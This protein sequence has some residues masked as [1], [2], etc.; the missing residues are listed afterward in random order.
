MH[1]HYLQHVPFEGL[2][3]IEPWL[4]AAG[5]EITNTRLFE[6]A[7]FPDLKKI[8]LLVIMGGPMSVNDENT[9]PWLVSEKQFICKAINSGNPVLGICLGAQLIASA[10][11]ARVYRNSEKEIGWFPI[12]GVASTDRSIFNFPPSMKVFHWHGETFDLPSGA[13]HLAKSDGC[14]NQAFQIGKSVIGLQFH[15]ETTPKAAWEIVSHCRKELVP[16]K[17]IQT[18]EEILS[19]TP[20]RYKSINQLMGS[21]LSFLLRKDG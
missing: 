1:A 19:A 14:E 10:M 15:L 17:Y 16:S 3:S 4:K 20:E 13:A 11:D 21:V 7:E 8:D 12:E 6:S 9:F 5:H 18:E 2:G